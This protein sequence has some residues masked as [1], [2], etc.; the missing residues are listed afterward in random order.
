[1][2]KKKLPDITTSVSNQEL[3]ALKGQFM[4]LRR[5]PGKLKLEISTAV[6]SWP[7]PTTA[8]FVSSYNVL[9]LAR[10]ARVK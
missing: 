5:S 1:M 3:Q 2:E 7:I 9:A 6:S 10:L 4:F 8:G